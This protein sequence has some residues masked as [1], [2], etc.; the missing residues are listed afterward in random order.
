MDLMIFY[1]YKMAQLSLRQKEMNV[2][3]RAYDARVKWVPS[4]NAVKVGT[5][6][7][8]SAAVAFFLGVLL[9]CVCLELCVH[10]SIS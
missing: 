8:Y 5:M 10:S 1:R 6:I 4:P 2:L 9:A 3:R 7:S